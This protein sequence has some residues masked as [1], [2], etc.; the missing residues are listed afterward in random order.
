MPERCRRHLGPPVTL[1]DAATVPPPHE[2]KRNTPDAASA[3]PPVAAGFNRPRP[4]EQT[5]PACRD[6]A[7]GMKTA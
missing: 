3:L 1:I 6:T 4:S 7:T 2:A 5:T